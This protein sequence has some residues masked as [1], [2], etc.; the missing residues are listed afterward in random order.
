MAMNGITLS[1]RMWKT[2]HPFFFL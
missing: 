1:K 2:V